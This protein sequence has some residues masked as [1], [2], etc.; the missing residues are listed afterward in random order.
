MTDNSEDSRK[1]RWSNHMYYEDGEL[2]GYVKA[3][4]EATAVEVMAVTLARNFKQ[5]GIGKEKFLEFMDIVWEV[6]DD[7]FKGAILED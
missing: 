7:T 5:N 1:L 6:D 2:R 3:Q 4:D